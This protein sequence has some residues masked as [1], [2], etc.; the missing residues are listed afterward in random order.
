MTSP[1]LVIFLSYSHKNTLFLPRYLEGY[2]LVL[3]NTPT[4]GMI[5]AM[6]FKRIDT[7]EGDADITAAIVF[8]GI[9]VASQTTFASIALAKLWTFKGFPVLAWLISYGSLA[10]SIA[11]V[12]KVRVLAMVLS[13]ERIGGARE[14]TWLVMIMLAILSG[15]PP[16][17]FIIDSLPLVLA[18]SARVS[19][20]LGVVYAAYRLGY[21]VLKKERKEFVLHSTSNVESSDLDTKAFSKPGIL[22]GYTTDTGEPLYI[23]D[24]DLCRHLLITGQT[25]VG[26]TVLL[27]TLMFQQ[28]QRGGGML[29]VDGKLDSDNIRD[30][31]EFASYC[32]RA[33]DFLVVNPGQPELSN[34]YNPILFGDPDEVAARI[35]SL[36]PSTASS[37]GADHYKQ[38]ANLALVCFISALQEETEGQRQA[39]INECRSKGLPEGYIDRGRVK[40]KAY[41]FLDLS[42]LTMNE[43]VLSQLMESV[44]NADKDSLTRKNLSIFLDQYAKENVTDARE[45]VIQVDIKKLKD[46]LGGIGARMHQFGSGNFGPVLN[47]YRPEVIMYEAIKEGKIV[48][49]ALPTMGK[50]EAAQNLGKI[51]ISDLKTAISWLQ[52]NKNDRP[53]IPFLAFMDEMSSYAVESLAVMFEQA[54]SARV[55][56]LPAIQTDSGLS[57]ISED[58]KERILANTETKIYFKLSSQE[59]A[60]A[61]AEMIGM[62]KRVVKSESSGKSDSTSAQALQVGPNKNASSGESKTDGE[63]EQ[64]EYL[65]SADQLKGL[66]IGECIVLRSRRVWNIRVPSLSLKEKIREGIGGLR[67]NHSRRDIK[68]DTFDAISKVD[69]YLADAQKSRVRKKKDDKDGSESSDARR[70]VGEYASNDLLKKEK[71]PRPSQGNSSDDVYVT[72][73]ENGDQETETEDLN[74]THNAADE[75]EYEAKIPQETTIINQKETANTSDDE[76]L[77]I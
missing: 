40:G 68:G 52:L 12:Y 74:L 45:G 20:L 1:A 61:A 10:V 34:T 38:S 48:Y 76:S 75:S 72:Q 7:H 3:P 58:F 21:S 73:A 43:G 56:L 16:F 6:T 39:W 44:V 14:T 50:V 28:I 15:L 62:T 57:N 8:A 31:Y 66:D 26:K 42:L 13:T 51:V 11:H 65:V 41:N 49:V 35:L 63:R 59:T 4:N 47:S 22:F 36:I 18:I 27:K 55:A 17:S 60:T 33:N 67:I 9:F 2:G 64:E 19:L 24:E 32:G 46:T 25:G 53:K 77:P 70:S 30:M 5:I 23:S 71:I 54:R 37:A 69:K 29:F